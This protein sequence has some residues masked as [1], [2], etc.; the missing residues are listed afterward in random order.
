[1][2]SRNTLIILFAIALALTALGAGHARAAEFDPSYIVSDSEMAD[3]NSMDLSDI[4][5]FLNKRNGTLVN[6]LSEDKEGMLKTAAQT[7]FEVAQRW[8]INPKY[9][10]LLVQKE[11]SLLEDSSPKQGQY[12]RATGYGC[13]DSGGCDDRFKGFYR[14]V[15]SA[16]AQTRYYL[17]NIKLTS[18]G[19]AER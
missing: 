17:D 8:M 18:E 10:M 16:A 6:Y 19:G 3:Y 9:L 12:D 14:Q 11:Q 4:Q 1:M 13:P 2:K 15:N 7:F 5:K